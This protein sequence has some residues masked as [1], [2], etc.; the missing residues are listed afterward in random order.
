MSKSNLVLFAVLLALPALWAVRGLNGS[1]VAFQSSDGEWADREVILKGR[2]FDE[3]LVSFEVYRAR[4]APGAVLQRITE[5]PSWR[6]P[7][8]WFNDYARPKWQVPLAG[9]LPNSREGLYPS[10]FVQ[11]CANGGTTP[12]EWSAARARA[13]R[14]L[15]DLAAQSSPR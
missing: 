13:Q 5:R 9:P 2:V 12:H 4:C 14:L 10:P 3:L 6:T 1:D 11:H 15:A 7:E 8:H